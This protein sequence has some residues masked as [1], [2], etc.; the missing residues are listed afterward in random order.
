MIR[1]IVND[2]TNSVEQSLAQQHSL[3]KN[4]PNS[5]TFTNT[6]N[7]SFFLLG[8]ILGG[9][10]IELFQLWVYFFSSQV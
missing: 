2:G 1:N 6:I 9:Q 7:K 5:V 8:N 10:D 4:L 3:S